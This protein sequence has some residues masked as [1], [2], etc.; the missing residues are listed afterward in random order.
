LERNLGWL[1]ALAARH[2]EH[3]AL[4]AAA[5]ATAVTTARR[6]SAAAS[7][8]SARTRSFARRTA[9]GTTI[10]FVLKSFT[11]EELLFSGTENELCAAVGA[12]QSFVGIQSEAPCC[13]WDGF[14]SLST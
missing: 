3:L 4:N 9:I 13:S 6:H 8:S 14:D 1:T 5:S 12:G 10:G 7:A 11:G 2:R